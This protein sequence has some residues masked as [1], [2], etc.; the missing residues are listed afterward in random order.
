MTIFSQLT[1]TVAKDSRL[2]IVSNTRQLD[3]NV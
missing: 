1:H 3:D 2:V